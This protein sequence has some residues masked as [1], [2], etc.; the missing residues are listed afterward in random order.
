[1]G[2]VM[3]EIVQVTKRKMATYKGITF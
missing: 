2:F 1:M 3:Q